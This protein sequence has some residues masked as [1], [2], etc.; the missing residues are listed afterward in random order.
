[1]EKIRVQSIVV[2]EVML[3]ILAFPVAFDHEVE[4]L[5]HSV[6]YVGPEHWSQQIEVGVDWSQKFV[7]G[8]S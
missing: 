7:V 1:M 2:P 8:M 6:S 3:V 4:E 5:C